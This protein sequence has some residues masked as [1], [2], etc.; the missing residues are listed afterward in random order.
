MDWSVTIY[1]WCPVP[2]IHNICLKTG[3]SPLDKPTLASM[4]KVVGPPQRSLL[5]EKCHLTISNKNRR[6]SFLLSQVRA[7]DYSKEY[8]YIY[9]YLFIY[10]FIYWLLFILFIYLFI[11]DVL[12]F[13]YFCFKL[14]C[15]ILELWSPALFFFDFTTWIAA[16]VC[17]LTQLWQANTASRGKP[18][19][20]G[21]VRPQETR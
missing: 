1:P 5:I 16:S 6:H 10:S 7:I 21:P 9:I 20:T 18:Y 14:Y 2:L 15:I 19:E 11:Y 12:I 17:F 8:I 3:L 4:T 13:M